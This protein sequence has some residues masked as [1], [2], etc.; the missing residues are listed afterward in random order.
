LGFIVNVKVEIIELAPCKKQLRFELP[1]EDVDAAFAKVTSTFRKQAN[2]PGYRKGKAPE[3]KVAAQFADKIQDQVREQ[4]LNDC[5]RK[6]LEDNKI[7]PLLQP[8]VEEVN[9]K[10]GEALNFLATV[11]TAPDFEMPEYKGLP[12]KKPKL[13]VA[14]AD[15]DNALNKLR[16][17]RAEYKEQERGTQAGD[18]VVVSFTGTSDGKPLTDFSPTARGMTKQENFPLHVHADEHD[19]FIPGFTKQLIGAKPGE[20]R[21]VTVTI[22]DEFPSQPKLQGLNVIYE[23]KVMQVKEKVL[24]ELTDE[25]A[26]SWEAESVEKLREGVRDDLKSNQEGEAMR[27]VRAQVHE[28]LMKKV[29]FAVPEPVQQNELRIVVESMVRTRRAGGASEEDIEKA[30]EQI[31]AEA[32]PIAM[33]RARWFFIHPLIA[34][35]EKVEV[36][37]EEVLRV[38]AMQAQ[39][40]G[41][42]PQQHVKELAD[43]NQISAI[44]NQIREQKVIELIAEHAEIELV[45]PPEPDPAEHDHDHGHSHG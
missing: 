3:A 30:K 34:E 14:D 19:H 45:D 39:Q 9:F 1:A 40:M 18:Y 26:K 11:E 7:R 43:N 32:N 25:F 27:V 6:G 33:D 20:E 24:P 4:L 22:P 28:E 44:Q 41:K 8:E 31:T 42:D 2:L 15:V 5:Y 36:S 10:R 29:S 13:E 35:T 17:G 38:I 23:V 12:A 37:R 21:T 16:E